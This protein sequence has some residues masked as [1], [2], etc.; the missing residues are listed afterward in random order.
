MRAAPADDS[1]AFPIPHTLARIDDGRP[2]CDASPTEALTLAGRAATVA[3]PLLAAAQVLPQT[4]SALPI[5]G[6]LLVDA[7]VTDR[8]LAFAGDLLGTPALEDPR[9]DSGPDRRV[10]ACVAAR[11][12]RAG[13]ARFAVARNAPRSP[14]C[15]V[16]DQLATDRAGIAIDLL[17]DR[18]NRKSAFSKVLNLVAFVLAQVRVAHVQF[19]LAVKLCR[20]PRLRLFTSSGD[21]LQN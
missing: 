8:D 3:S 11:S 18:T 1:V 7:F 4:A 16:A 2:L 12:P 20:L 10:N 9:F 6:D 17:G 5:G 14:C 15:A 19:H 13:A 21:A